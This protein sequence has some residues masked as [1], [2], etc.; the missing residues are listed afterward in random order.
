M[1]MMPGMVMKSW[2]SGLIMLMAALLC[3]SIIV[4]GLALGSS[5]Q[6]PRSIHEAA[7]RG[8]LAAVRRFLA[9]DPALLGALDKR[10]CTPL[11]RA[12]GQG[13]LEVVEDLLARGADVEAANL[14]GDRPLHS[15]AAG[16]SVDVVRLLI[17]NRADVR[18][19]N[20]VGQT[21]VFYAAANGHAKAAEALLTS[22]AAIDARDRQGW[23][24]LL[25]AAWGGQVEAVRFLLARGADPSISDAIGWTPLHAAAFEGHLECVRLLTTPALIERPSKNGDRPLHW[26][27]GRGHGEVVAF[28]LDKGADSK[29]AGARGLTSLPLGVE[30]GQAG[31]VELLLDRGEDVLITDP[32]HGRT[33]LHRAV[34]R[35]KTDVVSKLLGTKIDPGDVDKHGRTALDWAERLGLGEIRKR[36]LAAGIPAR[37]RP[38]LDVTWISNA[39]F[40]VAAGPD[41]VLID[42]IFTDIS[43]PELKE[44]TVAEYETADGLYR[45][46]RLLLFT[47]YHGDHLDP[48]STGRFMAHSPGTAMVGSLKTVLTYEAHSLPG[49]ATETAP[50]VMAAT[51]G[52]FQTMDVLA[53]GVKVEVQH[54]LHEREIP[55]R[56]EAEN[57]AYFFEVGGWRILHVGDIEGRAE[58]IEDFTPFRRMAEKGVDVVFLPCALVENPI[59]VDV[60]RD[61]FRPKTVVLMHYM[62][63]MAESFRQAVRRAGDRLPPIVVFEKALESRR[64]D[65]AAFP[66]NPTIRAVAVDPSSSP[67]RDGKH[68]RNGGVSPKAH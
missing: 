25:L 27:I 43:D 58:K 31:V 42:P 67:N 6:E 21:P 26:A 16:G 1:I 35:N 47:H 14:E 28:L 66:G 68:V 5:G 49:A 18:A 7:A 20:H 62:E 38:P 50:R 3:G 39:G 13:R 9:S 19:K 33:L 53:G 64:F 59:G 51:P 15:A 54:V 52:L 37:E 40:L 17:K 63:S 12:A 22:G 56:T 45:G 4:E 36:L 11:H 41:K 60:I 46:I 57:L 61:I 34:I 24:P 8:D 48:V 44:R 30:L 55:E 2:R 32:E 23:T 29:A 10:K 65:P